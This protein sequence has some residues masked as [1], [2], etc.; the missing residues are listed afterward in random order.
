[1][2]RLC[3]GIVFLT[4]F[5]PFHCLTVV[6]NRASNDLRL[7][8]CRNTYKKK[9][10]HSQQPC[11]SSYYSSDR[12]SFFVN[13]FAYEAGKLK[14]VLN[15]MFVCDYAHWEVCLKS[16]QEL[17]FILFGDITSLA[18]YFLSVYP[19]HSAASCQS[20]AISFPTGMPEKHCYCQLSL[21]RKVENL[22]AWVCEK[23]LFS[24]PM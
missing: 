10:K 2:C 18:P 13:K 22:T 19:S 24:V 23:R 7:N 12:N 21:A 20:M 4:A 8:L 11:N 9:K 16:H 17:F 15:W 14:G 5:V 1:M 3:A 6:F